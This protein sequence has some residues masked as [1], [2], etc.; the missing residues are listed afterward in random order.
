MALPVVYFAH[1]KQPRS[2]DEDDSVEI[3]NR[4]KLR[5]YGQSKS[6][7]IGARIAPIRKTRGCGAALLGQ[8][9]PP[10]RFLLAWLGTG[11]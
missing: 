1:H 10:R 4:L 11:S 9:E 8:I 5:D 2:M 7:R 3:A 6:E